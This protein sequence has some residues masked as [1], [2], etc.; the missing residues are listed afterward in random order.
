MFNTDKN[1]YKH[2][3]DNRKNSRER[4]EEVRDKGKVGN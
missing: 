3:I 1:R 2:K 4:E